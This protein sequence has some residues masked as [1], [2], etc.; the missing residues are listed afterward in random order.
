MS[1]SFL[2][3]VALSMNIYDTLTYRYT[4]KPERLKI[5]QRV[6]VPLLN[7]LT[8]GWVVALDSQ[9]KGR[10][11]SIIG[12]IDDHYLPGESFLKYSQ[13]VSNVYFTSTGLIL[14]G[15]VSP[16]NKSINNLY[17]QVNDELRKLKDASLKDLN[18]LSKK[19]AL[20]FFYK[21]KKK[22]ID[23]EN[24]KIEDKSNDFQTPALNE[25]SGE[26]FGN[27]PG[28]N[29]TYIISTERLSQYKELI[30][31]TLAN[32]KSL[33]IAVP[34]N[35]TAHFF[36]RYLNENDIDVDIYNSD[37]KLSQREAIWQ[38]YI[39]DNRIGVVIGGTSA[40]MLPIPNLGLIITE[41]AG[42]PMYKRTAF[43]KYNVHQMAQLRAQQQHIP[44]VEGFSTYTVNA[45]AKRNEIEIRDLREPEAHLNVNVHPIPA[46]EK[47]VP[48]AF[49][50]LMKHH[51]TGNRN[52]LVVV[53]RK[54][55]TDFLFCEKCKKVVKCPVCN[56]FLQLGEH[57]KTTCTRCGLENKSNTQC[58]KCN[59]EHSIVENLSMASVKKAIKSKVVETGIITLSADDFKKKD[60]AVIK[61][62]RSASIVIATPIVVNP[63]FSRSFDSVIYL[64]P[65][66][67]F[68]LDAYDAA[69][70]VFSMASEL[71]ELTKP[72]GE[73]DIFST[74]HFH[75]SLKLVNEE[76]EFF[77]REI[78]YRQWFHLPPFCNVYH[79]E[80]K[81]KKLRP[82]AA[83][84]RD[85]YR[86]Q[87][88]FLNIKKIY[89]NGRKAN[90]G[91]YK[92]IIEAH[93]LPEEIT[94]SGI[95]ENR[96]ISIHLELV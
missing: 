43:S 10:A 80:I 13:A 6:I 35:L 67:Q 83:V 86:D 82:L 85:I 66:S 72:E 70:R 22:V 79:I 88:E 31:E 62:V 18:S 26:P 74:F 65:E 69:E 3:R 84:M 89:L 44:L 32:K 76:K 49:I 7:R 58:P 9:Y 19:E 92:G 40:L 33:L 24:I 73:V 14:D 38:S 20:R 1:T 78:R 63:Y 52:V 16:K 29:Q 77:D 50:E 8:G 28:V 25:K 48:G 30:R 17:F 11:K 42:S 2:V 94:N 56:G 55:S 60:D 93:A 15:S 41:R 54:E 90:R 46:R 75:Y 71:K 61:K 4:G 51:S 12:L 64:R 34:D 36:Q 68:D 81:G 95:L 23:C 91:V 39:H 47:G 45:F 59:Q 53:N 37:I 96:D 57:F 27:V 21:T 87:K 5:G